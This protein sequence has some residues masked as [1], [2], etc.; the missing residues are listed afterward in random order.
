MAEYSREN[1]LFLLQG[2]EV[3]GLPR[4]LDVAGPLVLAVDRFGS[5][6]RLEMLESEQRALEQLSRL[7]L[8]V[9]GNQGFRIEPQPGEGLSGV[10]RAGAETDVLP[11]NNQDGRSGFCQAA[12]CGKA[13]V[14]CTNDEN[15]N[16]FPYDFLLV[17]SFFLR[18][19]VE[20]VDGFFHRGA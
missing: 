5:E 10:A 11:F 16:P 3:P 20:P 7:R 13:G 4:R 18:K 17:S 8:A 15:V 19:G 1:C 12:S 6:Q 2:L 9:S 14:T